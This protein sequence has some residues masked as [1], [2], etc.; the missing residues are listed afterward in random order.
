[1]LLV[2]NHQRNPKNLDDQV[3]IGLVIIY[4]GY[5]IIFREEIKWEQWLA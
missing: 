5:V 1:M 2:G 4:L 3:W